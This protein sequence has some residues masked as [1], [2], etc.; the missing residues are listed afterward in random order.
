MRLSLRQLVAEHFGG[1]A[2]TRASSARARSTA[3]C[4]ADA[5]VASIEITQTVITVALVITDL[6]TKPATTQRACHS[7]KNAGSVPNTPRQRLLLEL[8]SRPNL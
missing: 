5:A 7:I 2:N 6:L 1:W 3:G 8:S 4:C